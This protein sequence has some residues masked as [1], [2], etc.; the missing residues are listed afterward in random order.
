MH[1]LCCLGGTNEGKYSMSN[2][3][4]LSLR[5]KRYVLCFKTS[6]LF[7]EMILQF[8]LHVLTTKGWI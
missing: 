3:M 4:Q 1:R 6:R 7:S 8:M 5:H 2:T